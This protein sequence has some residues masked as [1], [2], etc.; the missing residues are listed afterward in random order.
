MTDGGADATILLLLEPSENR[1]LLSEW[2]TDEPGFFP[3]VGSSAGDLNAEFDLCLVDSAMLRKY[4]TEIAARKR[5]DPTYLPCLLVIPSW[6]S[7]AEEALVR[8][9][10]EQ[11]EAV[12]ETLAA[13][14]RRSVLRRRLNALLRARSYSLQ[15]SVSERRY[16]EL[17]ERLPEPVF[18]RRNGVVDYVNEAAI[19]LLGREEPTICDESLVSF[20]PEDE[21]QAVARY[22]RTLERDGRPAPIETHLL[23]ASDCAVPIELHGARFR[24]DDEFITVLVAR[25]LSVRSA[26]EE[27]I[28]LYRRA[29]DALSTG[30]VITDPTLPDHPIVYANERFADLVGLPHELL[31]GRDSY[32][33]YEP[34]IDADTIE[35]LRDAVTAG[36]PASVD[37]P[38]ADGAPGDRCNTLDLVPL[39]EPD[40]VATNYLG[41]YRDVTPERERD[42]QR[43][44]LYSILRRG[45]DARTDRVAAHL[46]EVAGRPVDEVR[47]ALRRIEALGEPLRIELERAAASKPTLGALVA[48][49]VEAKRAAH[50]E[51]TIRSELPTQEVVVDVLGIDVVIDELLDNA[52]VHTEEPSVSIQATLDDGR[53]T[54]TMSDTG[55]GLPESAQ[56]VFE[57]DAPG[58]GED[59]PGVGLWIARWIID[60]TEG[61]IWYEPNTPSGSTIG[62][63]LPVSTVNPSIN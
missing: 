37:L 29:L 3:V 60:Q 52:V 34:N 16:Y 38:A 10:D 18:V 31:R 39:S 19:T 8:L 28:A 33:I 42:A 2:L 49:L 23:H 44:R 56:R 5:I 43:R 20:A 55:P 47:P 63:D 57:S 1:R 46:D 50:P 26:K 30:V 58:P 59:A 9:P 6:V 11:I 15:L 22:L 40:G 21:Q 32:A 35:T 41:I 53:V 61:S 54:L 25:D 12:D 51:A 27:T 36:D 7:D 24:S 14:V 13:P 48:D 62:I 17:L 45:L 4:G